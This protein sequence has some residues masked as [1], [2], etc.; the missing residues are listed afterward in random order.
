MALSQDAVAALRASFAAPI[1]VAHPRGDRG[2]P[3]DVIAV[4][5]ARSLTDALASV[6]SSP[7]CCRRRPCASFI[8]TDR[9]PERQLHRAIGRH[10]DGTHQLPDIAARV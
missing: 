8:L 5:D 3:E 1:C 7:G 2:M 10:P 9:D 6:L 4:A